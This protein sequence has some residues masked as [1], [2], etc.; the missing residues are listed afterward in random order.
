MKWNK[1]AVIFSLLLVLSGCTE[2]TGQNDAAMQKKIEKRCDEIVQLYQSLYDSAEKNQPENRWEE[3]TLAQKDIDDIEEKLQKEGLDVLDSGDSVPEYLTTGS[4]FLQFWSDAQQGKD[5]CQEVLSIRP[6]GDL[7]YRL[8]LFQDGNAY[9]YSMVHS[10]N[11][12][13]EPDYEVHPILDWE[14]TERGHFYYR[15]HPLGDKHFASYSMIRL[16]KPDDAL[17]ALNQKYILA[18][19][20]TASNLFLTDWT[21]ADFSPV[22]FNDLWE[23]LYRYVYGNQFSPEGYEYSTEQHCFQIPAREFESLIQQFFDIDTQTLRN[24][25]WYNPENH[26]YPWRQIETNDFVDNFSF[27]TMEPEV[28]ASTE[29]PDGSITITVQVISTD[30][31]TDCAF[32][33]E[34]TV[35]PMEDGTFRFIGNRML[36]QGDAELPK[37][38]PRLTWPKAG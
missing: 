20:Y 34:V 10:L 7:G 14:I 8:F 4:K 2:P 28:T 29:N 26:T 11:Q 27:Y 31:K 30:L 33:H 25:A 21:E 23:Y 5:G 12:N 3:A 32:S 18:G 15:I 38:E 9:V 6:S 17:C 22:C 13:K 37:C 24:L 19:S 35:R 16:E 1:L 36:P